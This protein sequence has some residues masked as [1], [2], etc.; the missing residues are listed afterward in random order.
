MELGVYSN[1]TGCD[2]DERIASRT[3]ELGGAKAKPSPLGAASFSSDWAV[4]KLQH[5][6]NK[7]KQ[8]PHEAGEKSVALAS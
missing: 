2:Q 4:T 3:S 1:E 8:G 7:V 6:S 5:R